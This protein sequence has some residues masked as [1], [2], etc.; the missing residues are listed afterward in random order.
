MHHIL[1]KKSDQPVELSCRGSGLVPR[2]VGQ[3][4]LVQAEEC[5]TSPSGVCLVVAGRVHLLAML[6]FKLWAWANALKQGRVRTVAEKWWIGVDE[7]LAILTR[8]HVAYRYT[9]TEAP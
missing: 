4:W 2:L 3:G 5:A 8:G 9:A 6:C 7:P 1:G